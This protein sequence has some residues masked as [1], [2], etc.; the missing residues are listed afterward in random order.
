V[1]VDQEAALLA[2]ILAAFVLV[3]W[4]VRRP[5]AAGLRA[6]AGGA[7]TALVIA[8]PQLAAMAQAGVRGGPGRPHVKF[9]AELPSLFAPLINSASVSATWRS[10]SKAVCR[11]CFMV[12]A[13][14]EWPMR[15]LSAFQSIFA[16]RPAV[17]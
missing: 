7:V 9:A 6:V 14:S 5:G 3:P 17:A 4:L 16:S 8:S 10:A 11:Y 13:T 2:A 1:L 12:K 15:L